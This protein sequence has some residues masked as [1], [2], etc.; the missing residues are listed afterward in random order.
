[1]ANL[2]QTSAMKLASLLKSHAGSSVSYL[3]RGVPTVSFTATSRNQDYE[4]VTESTSTII[5]A[6]DYTF[7]KADLDAESITPREGD[8]ISETIAGVAYMFEVLPI[9]NKP[10]AEWLDKEG[11]MLIVHTKKVG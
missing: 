11:V 5:T 6:R 1:M 8:R 4:V 10:C 2:L 7:T 3:R 9:G